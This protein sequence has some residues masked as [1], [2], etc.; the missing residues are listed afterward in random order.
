MSEKSW[1]PLELIRVSAEYLKSKG[2]PDARLAAEMLLAHIL[3]VERIML[4]AGFEKVVEPEAVDQYRELIRRRAAREPTQYILGK[5]EFYSLTFEVNRAVLIPRP[6][7]ETLVE[8]VLERLSGHAEPKLA[9]LCTGSGAAA[10][11]VAANKPAARVWA[12]DNSAEAIEVARRNVRA[13]G[14]EERVTLLVGDL[15]RP[16]IENG[17]SGTFNALTA[18]PPYVGADELEGLQPEVRLYEPKN[19]LIPLDGRAD[20][21][22]GRLAEEAVK[23]LGEEGLAAFEIDPR[24]A[25][26]VPAILEQAGLGSVRI[27][28]DFRGENRVVTGVKKGEGK[29]GQAGGGGGI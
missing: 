6:E 25:Q 27:V 13:H 12:T 18:N 7:T 26:T 11:A 3:G 2:V 5:A 23:L 16:L 29:H 17:L 4:Y 19:A 14:V 21:L 10:I 8:L 1:T 9:D 20:S 22:Y 15:G 24:L 28:K